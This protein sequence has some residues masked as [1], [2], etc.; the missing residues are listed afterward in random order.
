MSDNISICEPRFFEGDPDPYYCGRLLR[1][2]DVENKTECCPGGVFICA[3]CFDP[4]SEF[5]DRAYD[6]RARDKEWKE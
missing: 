6:A 2:L 5:M 1:Q 4:F 3:N